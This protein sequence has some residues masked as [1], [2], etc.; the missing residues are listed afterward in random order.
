MFLT[1]YKISPF[2]PCHHKFVELN[3][4]IVYALWNLVFL[5]VLQVLR[6]ITFSICLCSPLQGKEKEFQNSTFS[7]QSPIKFLDRLAYEPGF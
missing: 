1:L 4:L 5:V 7:G 3:Y 6:L 2:R